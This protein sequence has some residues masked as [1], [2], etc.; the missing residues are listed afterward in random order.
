MRQ[1]LGSL[2]AFC[3][4]VAALDMQ[5]WR[6]A[7]SGDSGILTSTYT[8]IDKST[9]IRTTGLFSAATI[10]VSSGSTS[11]TV[12][13]DYPVEVE[14]TKIS[15]SKVT[16]DVA[17]SVGTTVV[18]SGS[19]K[20]TVTTSSAL[21]GCSATGSLSAL[22]CAINS[23]AQSSATSSK[24]S[25]TSGKTSATSGKTSATSGKTSATSSKTSATSGTTAAAII[26]LSS[27]STNS[28][29][30]VSGKTTNTHV[31]TTGSNGKQ[32]VV[33]IL[34]GC[35]FCGGGGI[36]L[37]G[38]GPDIGTYDWPPVP[39]FSG[40]PPISIDSNDDPSVE[41]S[42]QSK[43][44][45]TTSK[46]TSSDTKTSSSSESSCTKSST[47][48]IPFVTV[49]IETVS[50]QS[51]ASS[52]VV[53]ATKTITGCDI[54]ASASTST[55]TISGSCFTYTGV[56]VTPNDADPDD[57]ASD[58]TDSDDASDLGAPNKLRRSIAGRIAYD[59]D[60]DEDEDTW[61][62]NN[63]THSFDKRNINSLGQCSWTGNTIKYPAWPG[64]GSWPPRTG[65]VDPKQAW[66]TAQQ[67]SC[68]D[69]LVVNYVANPPGSKKSRAQTYEIDHAYEKALPAQFLSSLFSQ[70]SS[71]C[72]TFVNTYVQTPDGEWQNPDPTLVKKQGQPNKQGQ[73]RLQSLINL[74]PNNL[75]V[76]FIGLD[77]K[78]NGIKGK[79]WNPNLSGFPNIKGTASDDDTAW[80]INVWA[81]MGMAMATMNEVIYQQMFQKIQN[82]I[83]A[84]FNAFDDLWC[85][86]N[87]PNFA[88]SYKKYMSNLMQTNIESA[89]AKAT[90]LS[91]SLKQ[92]AVTTDKDG[93]PNSFATQIQNLEKT[94]PPGNMAFSTEPFLQFPES[95]YSIKRRAAAC[96]ATGSSSSSNTAKSSSG[97]SSKSKTSSTQA[98]SSQSSSSTA[99]APASSKSVASSTQTSSSKPPPTTAAPSST[100]ASCC[101]SLYSTV[102]NNGNEL[103]TPTTWFYE[104]AGITTPVSVMEKSLSK[105]C[106][107]STT[108]T[109][110]A[111]ATFAGAQIVFGAGQGPS[112][113]SS[114]FKDLSMAVPTCA[115]AG[116]GCTWQSLG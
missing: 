58:A 113:V 14:T 104:L 68:N 31:T 10:E 107:E 77:N 110:D 91:N 100:V 8:T 4:G 49:E 99:P 40:L 29:K 16:T 115:T 84:G 112:C 78:I 48:E 56:P 73:S 60:F 28:I 35:S 87:A 1:S 12:T 5:F 63:L 83:Y 111:A 54:T 36:E 20:S 43:N 114:A 30:S 72:T 64:P 15:S 52:K 116:A 103:I 81:Q 97:T 74:V 61:D 44:S 76:A 89:K 109:K 105:E 85:G 95:T 57:V 41:S 71:A 18:G 19:A 23:V 37:W 86:D 82:D 47:T 42:T 38:F 65:T 3:V 26:T 90:A 53:T 106:V 59:V 69:V 55:T 6:R 24:T 96:S 88:S 92:Y 94:Y 21:T 32:T 62:F 102:T 27:A 33:P 75:N 46:A 66:W 50:G 93:Q 51:S 70:S 101:V 80:N 9:T 39:S 11:A 17:Y 13:T 79:I 67:A 108:V 2:T 7:T 25:A 45:K 98:S 22:D 34:F